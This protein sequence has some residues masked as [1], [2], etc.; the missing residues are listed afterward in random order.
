VFVTLVCVLCDCVFSMH[1]CDACV[2]VAA[3]CVV[4]LVATAMA[5]VRLV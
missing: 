2:T 1:G 4:Q 3:W 5:L